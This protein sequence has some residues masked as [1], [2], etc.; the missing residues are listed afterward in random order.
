[1]HG[2]CKQQQKT[3]STWTHYMQRQLRVT[4]LTDQKHLKDR[5]PRGVTNYNGR[6]ERN[7]SNGKTTG[8]AATTEQH[9]KYKNKAPMGWAMPRNRPGAELVVRRTHCWLDMIHVLLPPGYSAS[10]L[11][12]ADKPQHPPTSTTPTHPQPQIHLPPYTWGRTLAVLLRQG[13]RRRLRASA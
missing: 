13:G 5:E 12:C 6:A 4:P 8:K 2:R 10:K 1:M 7:K 3:R 9:N 11:V